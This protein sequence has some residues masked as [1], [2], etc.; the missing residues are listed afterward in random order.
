MLLARRTNC[1]TKARTDK[2]PLPRSL[3]G[4]YQV[5]VV[6]MHAVD[7]LSVDTG[8][9]TSS[10]PSALDRVLSPTMCYLY[11]HSIY[12]NASRLEA[13]R[14][15]SA[16]HA[17]WKCLGSSAS[18][19]RTLPADVR[20]FEV[21]ATLSR[22][23]CLLTLFLF[24][25]ILTFVGVYTGL[26]SSLSQKPPPT[27]IPSRLDTRTQRS[28]SCTNNRTYS[29]VAQEVKEQP[30]TAQTANMI[31]ISIDGNTV[32]F[33]SILL[34]D[35]CQ[36]K[37][38][39]HESTNQRL[40]S[41]ADIP[42]NVEARDVELDPTSESVNITWRNDVAGFPEDHVTKLDIASLRQLSVSGCLPK[43]KMPPPSQSLWTRRALNLPDY[44]YNTYMKDDGMLYDVINQLRV[45]GLA[46]VTNVPGTEEALATI[47]TRIGPIKDTFY[48]Y[49][50]DGMP[51]APFCPLMHVQALTASDQSAP[52]PRPATPHTPQ[53]TWASTQTCSTSRTPRTSSS[54][55]ASSPHPQA[56]PASSQMP[57]AQPWTCS[58]P[59]RTPS[60]PSRQ[61][62]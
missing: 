45:D 25:T 23:G 8:I 55:T 46:F 21:Q 47:A 12:Q 16:G 30:G 43:H 31:P 48:G 57:T 15:E 9:K 10:V 2:S 62:P 19:D 28:F 22:S 26:T 56:A 53:T 52:F 20:R 37:S 49:T 11:C 27:S 39:V 14:C 50:W 61:S 13:Q 17:K 58:T 40:F 59:T 6:Q 1:P 3:P 18:L 60:T 34:R 36:C 32:D 33:S 44:D 54:S 4:A 42:A 7:T 29:A 51:T 35:A 41:S 38:C 5:F 24:A